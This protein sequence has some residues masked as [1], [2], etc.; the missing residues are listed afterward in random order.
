MSNFP[1]LVGVDIETTG[2]NHKKDMII[3]LGAAI[4]NHDGNVISE[5]SSFCNPGFKI[6]TAA[7][8]VNNISNEMVRKYPAPH[9]VLTNFLDWVKTETNNNAILFF[10]NASFDVKFILETAK[11]NKISIKNFKIVDTLPWTKKIKFYKSCKNY[12]LEYLCEYIGYSPESSHRALDDAKS[13]LELAKHNIKILKEESNIENI[14]DIFKL[15]EGV[16]KK[17]SDYIK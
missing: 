7:T 14:E 12:K 3:E 9:I 13:A 2:L 6:P 17:T 8:M 1:F 5:F 10:H 11:N 15:L 4:T 16:S